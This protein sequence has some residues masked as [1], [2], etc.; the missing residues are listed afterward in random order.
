[1]LEEHSNFELVL[2]DSHKNQFGVYDDKAKPD[3]EKTSVQT[4]ESRKW[5]PNT[6]EKNLAASLG[7]YTA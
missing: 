4:E 5:T 3:S 6:A 2:A 1:M 7:R